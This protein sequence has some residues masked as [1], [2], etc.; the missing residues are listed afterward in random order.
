M[1]G[2]H[3]RCT[4]ALSS[5]IGQTVASVGSFEEARESLLR[6]GIDLGVKTVSRLA[7]QYA[8]RARLMQQVDSVA[9]D[10]D[11]TGRK[12]VVSTDG[13]RVRIRT[14]KPGPK[15]QKGRNRYSTEWREPKV[16]IIYAANEDGR[17]DSTFVP[18]I[19]GV[20]KGPDVLFGLM[21]H[22]LEKLNIVAADKVLF[23]ADGAKWIWERAKNLL[24]SLG[25]K[26]GHYYELLDFYH[27][28]HANCI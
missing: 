22:Y 1:L 9:Y 2:I 8:Q 20:I 28:Y 16:L 7:Y 24:E 14:N 27:A 25:L 6:R 17:R 19:D 13:G 18:L 21:Q 26:P 3:D 11:T 10:A 5:E 12:I 4:S 15:T 23:V